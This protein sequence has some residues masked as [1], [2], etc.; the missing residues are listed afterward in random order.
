MKKKVVLRGPILTRSG[1]GEQTRFAYRALKSQSDKFDIFV[2]PTGWG[3]TGWIVEDTPEREELDKNIISTSEHIKH[4]NTL[5]VTPFDISIQVTIPQ[6]WEKLAAVNIGFTAGTETTHISLPWVNKSNEVDRIIAV[7]E[8]TK[9]GFTN[10]VY[11]GKNQIG[12]DVQVQCTTPVD[13]VNFPAKI[14]MEPT[15]VELDLDT[16]FNFLSVVQWGPRKNLE[17]TILGFIDEFRNEED[18]GLVVKANFMRNSLVDR[19]LTNS[20]LRKLKASAG[21]HKCKIYLVHGNMTDEEMLGLYTNNNIH[22]FIN[23]AHGEGFGL[24]IFEAAYSGLPVIA[25]NWGGQKDFLNAKVTRAAKLKSG[26]RKPK[27]K[28]KFLATDVDY[29]V[30]QIQKEAVWENVLIEQSMW[31]YPQAG[32]YKKAL[33][34]VY[35]NYDRAVSKAKTLKEIITTEFTE[36]K[37]NQKFVDAVLEAVSEH[38][39]NAVSPD[40]SN[41]V[42]T[43]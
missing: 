28:T 32:S 35:K 19:N 2:V 10:T 36:E 20:R 23:I 30:A 21:E 18:V 9:S 42:V 26:R 38:T 31:C 15:P 34:N 17:N 39:R 37:Q 40:A 8:H 7:S 25:P 22:A 1:Y 14:N 33:R 4:C 43:L 13:V 12:Q 27:T 29:R 24:P 11:T 5:G 41:Q 6:E 16:K 3:K